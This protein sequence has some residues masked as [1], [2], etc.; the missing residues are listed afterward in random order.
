MGIRWI[1]HKKDGKTVNSGWNS[2]KESFRKAWSKD[3]TSIQLQSE[4]K[5]LYTLSARKNSK[6]LFWQTDNFLLNS[7]TNKIEMMTRKIFKSLGENIWLELA[8]C[9]ESEKPF[10]N[11]INKKIKVG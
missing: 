11:I 1:I 8:F 7:N 6:T 4:D 10:I 3:I 9:N 2:N 5:K